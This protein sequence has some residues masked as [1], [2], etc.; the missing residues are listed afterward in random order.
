MLSY[1]FVFIIDVQTI[2]NI[3]VYILTLY[4]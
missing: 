1:I 2:K 3:E 4:L